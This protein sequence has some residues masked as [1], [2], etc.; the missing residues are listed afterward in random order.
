MIPANRLVPLRPDPATNTSDFMGGSLV[1]RERE[2]VTI[3][4]NSQV[5]GAARL[6][7]PRVLAFAAHV[8][9]HTVVLPQQ[10]VLFLPMPKAAC[11]SVLWTLAELVGMGPDDFEA[12]R[13]LA[14]Y[15]T[16]NGGGKIAVLGNTVYVANGVWNAVFSG[17]RFQSSHV[18]SLSW[19]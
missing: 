2:V 7:C 16:A 12:G 6:T 19:Q 8:R 1:C 4:R 10:R 18:N 14:A 17:V 3:T 11:T 5:A 9:S 13:T 15:I